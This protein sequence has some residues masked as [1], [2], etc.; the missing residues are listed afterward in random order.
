MDNS[1]TFTDNSNSEPSNA[2]SH[3]LSNPPAAESS[4]AES[5]RRELFVKKTI[6]SN[7]EEDI[8]NGYIERVDAKDVMKANEVDPKLCAER[9]L[10]EKEAAWLKRKQA[11]RAGPP[12]S[13]WPSNMP[14]HNQDT[15]YIRFTEK[16]HNLLVSKAIYVG[17]V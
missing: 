2:P 14:T 6:A 9:P 10:T 5:T 1:A 3:R 7:I 13:S 15:E 17:L 8:K 16:T 4:R 11:R 12:S